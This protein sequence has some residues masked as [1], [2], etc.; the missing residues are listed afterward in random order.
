MT[1]IDT[2]L[3]GNSRLDRVAYQVV[4]TIVVT[5]CRTWCRMTVEGR[6]NIPA[7]GPFLLCPVHRSIIDTPISSGV[8]RR[9]MRFM[10]ADKYWKSKW[11]GRL[12]SALGGFPVTRHSADREALQRCIAVLEGGEPLVLFPEGE[13][14]SGDV[15][16]PLFDGATYI[17]VKAGV[18]IVP[19]GIGGSERAMPK[20]AK[21]I[22]PRKVHVVVGAP[23]EVPSGQTGKA[24][25]VAIRQLTVVLHDELQRLL[26]QAQARTR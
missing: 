2:T 17:A 1:K 21:F 16:H 15:V 10:G 5:F 26:D 12:L 20:G 4:R 19:V 9:R 22:F 18:P 11:F 3:A 8:T 6:Q 23:I 14:K 13:R 7:E 24:Q 25:R